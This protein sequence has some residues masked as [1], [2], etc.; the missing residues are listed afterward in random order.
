MWEGRDDNIH[1]MYTILPMKISERKRSKFTNQCRS[2]AHTLLTQLH[3][4]PLNDFRT[5]WR[6]H[7][8]H[9]WDFLCCTSLNFPKKSNSSSGVAL[10]FSFA[11]LYFTPI[12]NT[13]SIILCVYYSEQMRH[14]VDFWEH[15]TPRLSKETYLL[16]SEG[17]LH[18]HPQK[19]CPLCP[20][21]PC[22]KNKTKPRLGG[23]HF[24][25]ISKADYYFRAFELVNNLNPW[26]K[27]LHRK[28]L[29]LACLK[30]GALTIIRRGLYISIIRANIL[31]ES[32]DTRA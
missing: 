17:P 19:H 1:E 15:L 10:Q 5:L 22:N 21:H 13:K 8:L 23:L 27:C 28:I 6:P 16:H 32:M 11:E 7:F 31:K 29:S 24:N 25:T 2:N 14:L 20:H 26:S 3:F 9:K 18:P 30:A 4:F 12:L